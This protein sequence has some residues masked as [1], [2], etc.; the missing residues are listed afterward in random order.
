MN[1]EQ[2]F[3]VSL[4]FT[5]IFEIITLVLITRIVFKIKTSEVSAGRLLFSG[6]LA[7]FATLPYVW[8]VLQYL[9]QPYELFILVAEVSVVLA[10]AV[11]YYYLL[12]IKLARAIVLS[13]SCNMTSFLLGTKHAL[14]LKHFDLHTN[15]LNSCPGI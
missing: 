4:L 2:A 15:S 9:I 8:F 7:S 5:W 12:N 1:Y 13:L 11:I 10:E 3:L 14:H 6:I